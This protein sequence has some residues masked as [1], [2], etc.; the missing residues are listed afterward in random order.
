M[1]KNPFHYV[2]TGIYLFLF[3]NF[4]FSWRLLQNCF[5]ACSCSKCAKAGHCLGLHLLLLVLPQIQS[6]FTMQ[7]SPQYFYFFFFSFCVAPCFWFLLTQT[8]VTFCCLVFKIYNL[9]RFYSGVVCL[10]FFSHFNSFL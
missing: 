6:G 7:I 2:E 4:C 8:N 5:A 3:Q 1:G 9:V 10:G